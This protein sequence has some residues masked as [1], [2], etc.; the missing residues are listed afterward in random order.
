MYMF[1]NFYF[2]GLKISK[3]GTISFS[4]AMTLYF[5]VPTFP[6]YYRELLVGSIQSNNKAT[7]TLSYLNATTWEIQNGVN[8]ACSIEASK[9]HADFFTID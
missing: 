5:P 6:M 1:T 4:K 8:I 7:L 3:E 9:G 2:T